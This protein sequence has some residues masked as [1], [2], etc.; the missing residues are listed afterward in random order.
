MTLSH[1]SARRRRLARL[2]AGTSAALV[3]GLALTACGSGSSEDSDV[4]MRTVTSTFTG[5][6]VEIP[7]K[8]ERVVTL[9]RTGS[10][11]ADLGVTPVAS[12]EGEYLEDELGS[13]VY[14]DYDD[15]DTVGT[16]EGV[17]VEKVLE[18]DPD[19][20]IGMDNGALSIDYTEIA[21]HVPVVILDIAEPT[22]VWANYPTVADLLGKTTEYE[23]KQAAIDA[24]LAAIKSEY[25]DA[26]ASL[27]VTAL[28]AS[29]ALYIE[30]SKSLTYQRV[31]A[32][33][34]GYNSVYTDNPERYVTELAEENIADL[35]NQDA[36]FYRVGI[37]G[38]VEPETQAIL[39][40]ESFKRLPAVQSG[41]VFPLTSGVNY[42]F[43]A[44]EAQV[45]DLRAAAEKLAGS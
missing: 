26:L 25:G 36:I 4:K 18:A 17:D 32:A 39:D 24:E 20:V 7:V 14:A 3:A 27:E 8:P 45:A 16:F 13:E 41:N 2:V 21:K 22:D 29:D 44:A 33:G 37:D 9:W 30:T 23:Q 38:S 28:S 42:T 31:N 6:D 1:L 12:L 5:E 19:L 11:V 40:S 10:I 15:I 35:A 43:A 34:Y